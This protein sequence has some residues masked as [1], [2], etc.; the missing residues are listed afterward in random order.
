MIF[1]NEAYEEV[2]PRVAPVKLSPKK[3]SI[4][5]DEEEDITTDE[6]E[7]EVETPDT[8]KTDPE[9]GQEHDEPG[10]GDSVS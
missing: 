6:G 5:P 2:Y 4:L 1:N 10:T 8:P 9:E 3:Q 7:I